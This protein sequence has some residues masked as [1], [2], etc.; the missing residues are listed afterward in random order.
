MSLTSQN[1]NEDLLNISR[2]YEKTDNINSLIS[3]RIFKER[4]SVSPFSISTG[5][6]QKMK[7]AYRNKLEHI[8]SISTT[9]F[10]IYIDNQ[11]KQIL[12]LKAGNQKIGN[13]FDPNEITEML[14][15][16]KEY[17]SLK[18]KDNNNIGYKVW[19]KEEVNGEIESFDVI[20][21]KKSFL[22][23]D[24]VLYYNREIDFSETEKAELSSPKVQITFNYKKGKVLTQEQSLFK[25][26][27]YLN[28]SGNKYVP[29]EKFRDYKVNIL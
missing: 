26:N 21:D 5:E 22:I 25:L 2:A 29:T 9:E 4:N 6:Y 18:L 19:L 20:F 16:Y 1:F 12:Y 7:A 28:K 14:K 8:E 13:S 24:L 15:N 17:K 10:T 3:Y 11:E 23:K 27:Y